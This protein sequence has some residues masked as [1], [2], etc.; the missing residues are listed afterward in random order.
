MPT[1][2]AKTF[3]NPD[4]TRPFAANG[5]MEIVKVGGHTVG[6]GTYEPGWRWSEH[7]KPLAQTDSC[8]A[9]HV[10]YILSGRMRVKMDDGTEAEGGSVSV[11]VIEPG[12]VAWVVGNEPCILVDFGASVGTYAAQR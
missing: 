12:H 8:E 10:G 3:D 9:T 4:E 7:V 6:R 1:L 5:K 11:A 2:N